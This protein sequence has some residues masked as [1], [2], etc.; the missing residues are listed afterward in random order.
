MMAMDCNDKEILEGYLR[1]F[2]FVHS[3]TYWPLPP[4]QN[5][6]GP[7][8]VLAFVHINVQL[9]SDAFVCLHLCTCL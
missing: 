9:L 3:S 1:S 5:T 7:A 6:A 2:S 4:E 8:Y